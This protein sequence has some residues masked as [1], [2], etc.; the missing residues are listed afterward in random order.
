MMGQDAGKTQ[1]HESN[2][3]GHSKQ[4]RCFRKDGTMQR[5]RRANNVLMKQVLVRGRTDRREKEPKCGHC[6]LAIVGVQKCAGG[7]DGSGVGQKLAAS[8]PEV[9][10]KLVR[11]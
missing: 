8:W 2:K 1:E 3:C 9:G 6:S 4:I 11:S 7:Q 5:Q 10:Q